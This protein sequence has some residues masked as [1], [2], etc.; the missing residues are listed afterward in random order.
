M[1]KYRTIQRDTFDSIA[2]RKWGNSH[3]CHEVMAENIVFMDVVF[4]EPGVEI[5][6]PEVKA[7]RKTAE[8]PPWYGVKNA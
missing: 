3:L 5:P 4:F 6:L 7:Q 8:L 2:F 1:K